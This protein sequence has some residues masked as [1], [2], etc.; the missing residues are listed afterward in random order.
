MPILS[1]KCTEI[2]EL[3][4]IETNK[5]INFGKTVWVI[6]DTGWN[7]IR[8]S[9]ETSLPMIYET[10]KEADKVA[11]GFSFFEVR[12]ATIQLKN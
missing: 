7:A 6:Y 12:E 2:A 3:G 4:I 11:D 8:T 10:K 5:M 1:E 9:G